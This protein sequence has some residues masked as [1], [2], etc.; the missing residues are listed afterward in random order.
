MNPVFRLYNGRNA[1]FYV[2]YVSTTM[3][4]STHLCMIY[5]GRVLLLVQ[6]LIEIQ[7]A[8]FQVLEV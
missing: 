6:S 5:A 8:I 3:K 2:F 1:I 7:T 4:R